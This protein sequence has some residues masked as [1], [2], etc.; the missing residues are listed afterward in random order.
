MRYGFAACALVTAIIITGAAGQA[1]AAGS[2]QEINGNWY[3][4]AVKAITYTGFGTT[5]SYKKVTNMA[6]GVCGSTPFTYGG[7]T[8]PMDEE[9]GVVDLCAG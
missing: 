8:S 7:T 9:V 1:C 2:A 4:Q 3:C 6:S 5:G